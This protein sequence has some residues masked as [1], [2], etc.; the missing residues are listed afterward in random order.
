MSSVAALACVERRVRVGFEL[1][2]E[3]SAVLDVTYFLTQCRTRHPNLNLGQDTRANRT[4]HGTVHGFGLQEFLQVLCTLTAC[5][6]HATHAT[7]RCRT[8]T[9]AHACSSG[10]R[11]HTYTFLMSKGRTPSHP[12]ARSHLSCWLLPQAILFE[13]AFAHRNLDRRKLRIQWPVAIRAFKS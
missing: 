7:T 5:H 12:R 11:C 2:S 13:H 6:V 10:K 4:R 9:S 3:N 8:L 1:S